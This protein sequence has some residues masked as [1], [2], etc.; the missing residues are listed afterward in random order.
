MVLDAT[1]G[2]Q[3]PG[4]P[5]QDAGVREGVRGLHAADHGEDAA[6]WLTMRG[7]TL[8]NLWRVTQRP[9][10][11][12]HIGVVFILFLEGCHQPPEMLQEGWRTYWKHISRWKLAIEQIPCTAP[13]LVN[14]YLS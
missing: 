11:F 6:T 1:R 5:L 8:P 14:E 2:D 3:P 9:L 7:T 12:F 13:L 4:C 10:I